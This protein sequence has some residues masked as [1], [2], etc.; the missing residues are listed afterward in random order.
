MYETLPAIR[1]GQSNRPLSL[2]IIPQLDISVL[3]RHRRLVVRGIECSRQTGTPRGPA[4]RV[5]ANLACGSRREGVSERDAGTL[6]A[7]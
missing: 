7:P 3:R 2:R 6:A 1:T 5:V 4:P